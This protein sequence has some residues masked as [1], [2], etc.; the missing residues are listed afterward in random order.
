MDPNK[1]TGREYLQEVRPEAIGHLLAFFKESG[2]HLEPKT[3]F[4]MSV[5]TKVINYTPRGL[6]QY[7]KRAAQEGA[8]KDEVIDTILLSY[9]CAGLTKVCDAVAIMQ[10]LDIPEWVDDEPAWR[11]LGELPGI[12]EGTMRSVEVDGQNLVLVRSEG[13]LYALKD[14]CPHQNE[15]LS[16]GELCGGVLTCARHKWQFNVADGSCAGTG[17]GD[18]ESIPVRE[19]GGRVEV[20]I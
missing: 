5:M 10:E 3:R 7:I 18:V 9:P 1:P 14:R 15:A 8:S 20:F 11:E 4:L 12:P 17:K 2:R 13:T 6:R 19:E 16:N